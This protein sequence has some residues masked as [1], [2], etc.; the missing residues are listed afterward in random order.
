MVHVLN[1]F[2][3]QRYFVNQAAWREADRLGEKVGELGSTTLAELWTA[4]SLV[5]TADHGAGRDPAPRAFVSLTP[6]EVAT[7]YWRLVSAGEVL[8]LTRFRER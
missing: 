3:I 5:L 8:E 7:P 2:M 1:L 4:S 6:A